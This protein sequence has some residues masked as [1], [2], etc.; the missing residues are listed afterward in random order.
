ML[1]TVTDHGSGI[2]DEI[3]DRIFDPFFTTKAVG[4]GT[5]LGLSTAAGIARSHSGSITV[6]SEKGKGARFSIHLPASPG[7]APVD[8]ENRPESVVPGNG[9]LILVVD[10]EKSILGMTRLIL[11][12]AGYRIAV[13]WDGIEGVAYFAGHM[14]E[15]AIVLTDVYMPNLDGLSLVH[16]VR[17]LHPTIPIIGSTGQTCHDEERKLSECG[18][19]RF[20]R[21]PYTKR[22]LLDT[23]RELLPKPQLPQP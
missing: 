3:K 16:T 5:G 9:E 13:A 21:K 22:Q 2:P 23:I 7:E 15:V 19:D 18:V 6:E 12:K 17:K 14:D 1:L 8:G 10:D 11:E 20:L 4:K